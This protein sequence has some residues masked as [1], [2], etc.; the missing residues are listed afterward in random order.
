MEFDE[1]TITPSSPAREHLGV[2]EINV[3]FPGF[4]LSKLPS[5]SLLQRNSLPECPAV[6]PSFVTTSRVK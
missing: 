5:L 3:M 6:Y 2:L 1:N 4:D